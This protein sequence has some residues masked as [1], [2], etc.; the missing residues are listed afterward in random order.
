[1]NKPASYFARL[2]HRKASPKPRKHSEDRTDGNVVP[3]SIH[4]Q[5]NRKPD[6]AREPDNANA[7]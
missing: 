4:G 1:M 3:L 5:L 2:R 7:F 6:S